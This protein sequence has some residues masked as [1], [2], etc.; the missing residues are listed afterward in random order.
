MALSPMSTHAAAP[1]AHITRKL[2]E[3]HGPMTAAQFDDGM[4]LL[5]ARVAAMCD[6]REQALEQAVKR[7]VSAALSESLNDEAK[8]K[9]FWRTGFDELSQHSADGA[10]K[11][12]GRRLLTGFV[13]AVLMACVA[14]LA[15]AGRLK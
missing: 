11:W 1:D 15:Q 3:D 9:K 2:V 14:W 7:G 5:L 8:V 4:Q 10:S 12:V 6:A 13:V